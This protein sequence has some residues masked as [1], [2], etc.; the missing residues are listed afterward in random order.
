[1][2]KKQNKTRKIKQR[3]SVWAETAQDKNFTK[4]DVDQFTPHQKAIALKVQIVLRSYK[5]VMKRF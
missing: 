2:A 3:R 4:D 1:M 5:E